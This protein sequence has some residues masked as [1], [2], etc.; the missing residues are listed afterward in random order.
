MTVH[1]SSRQNDLLIRNVSDLD[2][3][4]MYN[5]L[6]SGGGTINNT[7]ILLLHRNEHETGYIV[8]ICILFSETQ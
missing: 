1:T 3:V 4:R 7:F 5:R 2:E 8:C 6:Q